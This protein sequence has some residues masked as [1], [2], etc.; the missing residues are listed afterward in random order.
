MSTETINSLLEK[1]Q[2]KLNKLDPELT[3]ELVYLS[4]KCFKNGF[5][6][7]YKLQVT[8]GHGRGLSLHFG[9]GETEEEAKRECIDDAI[10][11]IEWFLEQKGQNEL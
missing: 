11:L 6:Y 7:K 10:R 9:T 2:E 4:K 8:K 5:K 3:Y 1:L